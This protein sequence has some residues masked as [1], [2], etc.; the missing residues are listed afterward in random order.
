MKLPNQQ[1]PVER[2]TYTCN[3]I[4]AGADASGFFGSAWDA[5]KTYGPR[6]AGALLA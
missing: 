6:V 3:S 1:Q 2:T 5:I 4:A